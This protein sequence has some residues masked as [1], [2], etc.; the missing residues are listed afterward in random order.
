LNIRAHFQHLDVNSITATGSLFGNASTATSA[1][2]ANSINPSA[3]ITVA[4]LNIGSLGNYT[5]DVSA[6][7][8]GVPVNGV[9]RN[10]NFLVIR[11]A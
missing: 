4:R 10:G 3:N 9:Y 6:A 2:I 1:S 5:D 8:G 11:V 7:A